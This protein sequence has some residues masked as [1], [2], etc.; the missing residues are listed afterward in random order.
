MATGRRYLY[1]NAPGPSVDN[2]KPTTSQS[3]RIANNDRPKTAPAPHSKTLHTRKFKSADGYT[4]IA[5]Y[6]IGGFLGAGIYTNVWEVTDKSTN[7]KRAMKIYE[8]TVPVDH[9]N[10]VEEVRQLQGCK[11]PSM[12]EIR[13]VF[14]TRY[15]QEWARPMRSHIVMDYCPGG[16]MDEL[17]R[18]CRGWNTPVEYTLLRKWMGQIF[19][20]MLYSHDRGIS[21]RDLRPN[22]L[23][24][25][26]E[27]NIK[28]CDFGVQTLLR[29]DGLCMQPKPDQF[30]WVAP[31][32]WKTGF[33]KES[34]IWSVGCI[35]LAISSCAFLKQSQINSALILIKT[36]KD[37][38]DEIMDCIIEDYS[39]E[40]GEVIYRMLSFKPEDRTPFRSMMLNAFVKFSMW[41]GGSPVI[42]T[43]SVELGAA[44]KATIPVLYSLTDS[45][46]YLHGENASDQPCV[47]TALVRINVILQNDYDAGRVLQLSVEDKQSLLKLM[48][49][50]WPNNETITSLCL[51]ILNIIIRSADPAK[52]DFDD[53]DEKLLRGAVT[54]MRRYRYSLPVQKSVCAL[55]LHTVHIP[56]ALDYLLKDGV[57]WDLLMAMENYVQDW[58]IVASVTTAF[59]TLVK[60]D[61]KYEVIR[62]GR[63]IPTIYDVLY[64]HEEDPLVLRCSIMALW[65]VA[66]LDHYD[67]SEFDREPL[68]E[69]VSRIMEVHQGDPGVCSCAVGLI[70]TLLDI[71]E[72]RMQQYGFRHQLLVSPERRQPD[73]F[74]VRSTLR[75]E[76]SRVIDPTPKR[77]VKF[78]VEPFTKVKKEERVPRR[79]AY[80]KPDRDLPAEAVPTPPP[81]P[82]TPPPPPHWGIHYIIQALNMF[83]PNEGGG[84]IALTCAQIIRIMSG[85]FENKVLQ[86]ALAQNVV[87]HRLDRVLTDESNG[88][89]EV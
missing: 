67:L 45:L 22:N 26:K 89:N 38:L 55:V 34:D 24:L 33:S 54:E 76:P 44:D 21:H 28:I 32:V 42:P 51:D 68:V 20:A 63:L 81:P 16:N 12:C 57:V 13:H 36:R 47:I 86:G 66:L 10:A 82:P 83:Q 73:I 39:V 46:K 50:T 17:L 56:R 6:K 14:M 77:D 2:T 59:C 25:T 49:Q 40:L 79:F 5:G 7:T 8:Y 75:P 29:V 31:E 19:D 53:M 37:V 58:E 60:H 78:I 69:T 41:L 88:L 87:A 80:T 74:D 11:H 35:L 30:P 43:A 3:D 48:V 23:L 70:H 18:K 64:I 72:P 27:L 84:T 65:A 15:F 71:T 61:V 52:H 62:K 9:R 1:G 85:L 4:Q